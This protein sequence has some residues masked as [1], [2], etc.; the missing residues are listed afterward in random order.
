MLFFQ[1]LELGS[2]NPYYAAYSSQLT[3]VCMSREIR[4]LLLVSAGTC[5]HVCINYRHIH[6]L[7]IKINVKKQD[8]VT[9]INGMRRRCQENSFKFS[10]QTQREN[11]T[12]QY[13]RKTWKG[14]SLHKL[15]FLLHLQNAVMTGHWNRNTETAF[16]YDIVST[17]TTEPLRPSGYPRMAYSIWMHRT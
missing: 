17:I 5:T 12:C 2:Q 7:K 13:E 15:D 8:L 9:S 6:I 3:T 4:H 14:D 1:G 10:S 16:M 11:A